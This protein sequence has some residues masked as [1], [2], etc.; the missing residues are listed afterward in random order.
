MR[1]LKTLL[2]IV[3]ASVCC[4]LILSFVS[5]KKAPEQVANPSEKNEVVQ[6]SLAAAPREVLFNRDIRPILNTSCTGCHGGVKKNAGVSFIYRDEA[7]GVSSNG[8]KIII[9]GDPDNSEVIKRI[10]S[11][12]P[13]YVMPPAHGDHHRDPL[14]PQEIELIKEWVRQ[15]AKYE[16]H[17][18][19]IPPK[20]EPVETKLKDWGRKP[21]D[22]YVLANLEKN[23]LQPSPEAP[24]AQWLRRAALDITGLPPTNAELA[25]FLADQSPDAFEKTADRLLASPRFGERWAAMWMDLARYSDSYGLEKDPHREAWPYR[26]WLIAAFN[27]DMPYTEFVRDQLAG[28]LADK[29]TTDQLKATLFQRLTKTN[30]EGGTDDEQFRVEA[31]IDR[32]S[33]NWNSLQGITM[34]CVQC[35]S[36]PYEPIP[37]E[38]FF[39]FMSYFNSS[40]DCD[41]DDDFPKHVLAS[42][43]AEQQ[44]ATDA[45]L[46]RISLQ[47]QRNR[48]GAEWINKDQAWVLPEILDLKI[49]SGGLKHK[50][51]I[52]FTE[53]TQTDDTTYNVTLRPPASLTPYTAFKFTILP[54]SDDL[55]KA[56][57]RGSVLSN[58]AIS[59]VAPDGKRTPVPLSF[60]YSD[61][62]AG[63]NA[64]ERSLDKTPAG[65]GG[66]PKLFRKMEAVIV[67][68]SPL[69]LAEGETL[70][71][72]LRSNMPTTGSQATPLRKF[73]IQ[74]I[75]NPGWQSLINDPEHVALTKRINEL[76]RY[77]TG[78]KGTQ[79]PVMLDRP[80][81][82]IR[83][84]R[85]WIGGNAM[86]KGKVLQPG[87]PEILNPYK[88]PA[89]NRR[90]MAEWMTHPENSLFSRVFVNRVFFE[91]FGNGIVQTLGDFGTTGLKPTNQPLLDYLAVAFRDDYQWKPKALIKEMVLSSTYRQDHKA[92]IE[93][94]EQDPKNILLAR[95]P[96]TRLTAE[97]IRDQAL[98]VSGLLAN[99]DGGPSVM[100]PQ[101]GG[102]GAAPYG[103]G[104]KWITA[105]GPDRFRRA[106]YTYWKR[107]SPFPSLMIFDT[108]MRDV[109]TTQRIT[110]NTPL[111]PLVTLN[112]PAYIEMARSLAQKM[113]QAP[114]AG[115]REKLAFG[116]LLATQNQPTVKALDVLTQ[117]REDLVTQYSASGPK[118]LADT[119][120]QAAMINLASVLLN[121][122]TALTK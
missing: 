54:D 2:P 93:L 117:L 34:G 105:E 115:P 37:H 57:F 1:I 98:A 107:T 59:K 108:P 113:E 15:G 90:E 66:Y 23:N 31:V 9:P 102:G 4:P 92:S 122:D 49:N 22:A 87:V 12:D 94:A 65:F 40:E 48:R 56:P 111:Q 61:A 73:Q 68:Q 74:L 5:C 50:D 62:L 24:K 99:R 69:T 18:A 119:P 72:D 11:T 3:C 52:I 79:F 14:K 81:E 88:A 101:P 95:G 120:D 25:A 27:R 39:A 35:H 17:W 63:P 78:V 110:T 67:L 116:Y 43:P 106:L 44:K 86:N 33:T 6:A 8:K 85:L 28:D 7:L 36:H 64:P 109:C 58:I 70:V 20:K 104:W 45:Q 121:L 80:P 41:L 32:I 30:T 16:E 97:M 71:A 77:I 51:G 46:E 100:P 19:Y 42:D 82:S 53:G 55:A 75:A 89:R 83:E 76:N 112:D 21:M 114:G 118:P 103:G 60:V 96:R 13:R 91:L 29:P 84:T 47:N 38:S 10:T 26:D